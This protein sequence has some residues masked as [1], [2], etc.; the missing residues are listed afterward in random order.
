MRVLRNLAKFKLHLESGKPLRPLAYGFLHAEP[1]GI[2]AID[3][4][5]GP[6]MAETR[7]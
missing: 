7:L 5:G 3:Q 6:K 1:M 4:S 2:V